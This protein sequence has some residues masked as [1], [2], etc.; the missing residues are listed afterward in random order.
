MCGDFLKELPMLA[1]VSLVNRNLMLPNTRETG[2]DAGK[3]IAE[4]RKADPNALLFAI[5]DNHVRRAAGAANA[6]Q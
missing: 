3:G 2:L 6:V 4:D 1:K 5:V